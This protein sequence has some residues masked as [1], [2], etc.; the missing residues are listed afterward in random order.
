MGSDIM[1]PRTGM[2]KRALDAARAREVRK[3]LRARPA[4]RTRIFPVCRNGEWHRCYF[5]HGLV[6]AGSRAKIE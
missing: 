3:I 1:V 5:R 2:I 4:L 6:E